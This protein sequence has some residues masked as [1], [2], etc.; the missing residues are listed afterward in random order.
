MKKFILSPLSVKIYNAAGV[1][2]LDAPVCS[3]VN[4]SSLASGYYFLQGV[5]AEGNTFSQKVVI[6]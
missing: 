3:S 6:K 4:V 5:D 1:L 2:V